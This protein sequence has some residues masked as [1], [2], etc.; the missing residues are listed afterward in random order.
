[1][2]FCTCS[3]FREEGQYQIDSFLARNTQA[4]MR[5]SP[6][7]LMPGKAAN[8]AGL[9]DNAASSSDGFFYAVLEQRNADL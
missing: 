3:V 2:V 9:L 6:G 1:M 7:H 8:A 4:V 5:P